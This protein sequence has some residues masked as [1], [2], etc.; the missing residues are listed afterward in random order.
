MWVYLFRSLVENCD[1]DTLGPN[2]M[3]FRFNGTFYVKFRLL[4]NTVKG[5][6]GIKYSIQIVWVVNVGMLWLSD[7]FDLYGQ[8]LRV[9]VRN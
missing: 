3:N 5:N 6:G 7:T 8:V 2:E 4:G 1:H 9:Q